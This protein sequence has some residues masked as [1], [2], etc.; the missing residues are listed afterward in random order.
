MSTCPRQC[1]NG[2]AP[3]AVSEVTVEQTL[4][5]FD[6]GDAVVGTEVQT[7]ITGTAVTL[8]NTPLTGYT[9]LVFADGL[10]VAFTISGSAVTLGSAV[11]DAEIRI[12]YAWVPA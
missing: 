9:P 11:T 2:T 1:F 12:H 5:S 4:L 10:A 6:D 7:G 3:S 8:A